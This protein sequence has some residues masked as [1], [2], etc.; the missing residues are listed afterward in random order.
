RY[1]ATAPSDTRAAQVFAGTL[2]YNDAGGV[3]QE[4]TIEG[5]SVCRAQSAPSNPGDQSN[6][7]GGSGGGG[8][9]ITT[10]PGGS[11]VALWLLLL[12]VALLAA[13]RGRARGRTLVATG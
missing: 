1:T 5:Q 3:A 12:P 10:P 4:L 8:C 9:A 13:R 6:A 7:G 11:G 2:R